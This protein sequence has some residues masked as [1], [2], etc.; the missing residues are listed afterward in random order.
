MLV[1]SL[2]AGPLLMDLV[3]FFG[4]VFEKLFFFTNF[5]TRP[6]CVTRCDLKGVI[7]RWGDESWPR[8]SH[9][10]VRVAHVPAAFRCPVA[11]KGGGFGGTLSAV[12]RI[13][14]GAGP[15]CWC[16]R[17]PLSPP[18]PLPGLGPGERSW[19]DGTGGLTV[20]PPLLPTWAQC[21]RVDY[22]WNPGSAAVW[23]PAKHYPSPIRWAIAFSRSRGRFPAFPRAQARDEGPVQFATAGP[24]SHGPGDGAGW[25][26]GAQKNLGTTAPD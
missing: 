17:S 11:D 25:S 26:W 5:F 7:L 20:A 23:R 24:K 18:G 16:R 22:W 19:A 3:V 9:L 21:E 15:V 12:P 1:I 10:N 8:K 2:G 14:G 6:I 13:A 4:I